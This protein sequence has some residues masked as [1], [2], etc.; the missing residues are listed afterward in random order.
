MK[1]S[2][3]LGAAFAILALSLANA[4]CKKESGDAPAPDQT[5]APG[6]APGPA[7]APTPGGNPPV[8][9][10]VNPQPAE[11]RKADFKLDLNGFVS[12]LQPK[13]APD[14]AW[15]ARKGKQPSDHAPVW[16][17]FDV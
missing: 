2:L 5:P 17:D 9:P 4:G 1:R 13:Q 3:V 11:T 6:P 14:P 16:T 7:P 12:R 15:E 8:N 10:P